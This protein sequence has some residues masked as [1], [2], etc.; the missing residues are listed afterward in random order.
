M[1][2]NLKKG[3]ILV[4]KVPPFFDHEYFYE[5][6]AA[7]GKMIRVSLY[8]SPKV[9]KHWSVEEYQ[10]LTEHGMIRLAGAADLERLA[11]QEKQAEPQDEAASD[12]DGNASDDSL[13][14]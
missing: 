5:V 12:S 2:E 4:V 1:P 3:Q 6:I 11:A 7:G 9:K 13:F 14:L 8:K 10:L